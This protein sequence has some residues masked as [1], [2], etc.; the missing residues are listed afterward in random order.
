MEVAYQIAQGD[1]G[2]AATQGSLALLWNRWAPEALQVY[3]ETVKAFEQDV[4][5][6]MANQAIGTMPAV[7]VKMAAV[8]KTDAP[9][10]PT[11]GTSLSG[12]DAYYGGGL[13]VLGL[14]AMASYAA[15]AL[16]GWWLWKKLRKPTGS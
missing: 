11:V 2:N 8:A 16:G 6:G 10:V 7:Y 3:N 4:Q 12:L 15:A 5:K 14:V 9:L 13:E 1:A